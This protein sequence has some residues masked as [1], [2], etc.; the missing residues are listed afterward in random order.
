MP[1][2]QIQSFRGFLKEKL[3]YLTAHNLE[4]QV[5]T[6]FIRLSRGRDYRAIIDEP[7]SLNKTVK[8]D[9]PLLDI[10]KKNLVKISNII[11]EIHRRSFK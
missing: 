11:F 10:N 8:I 6:F 2:K 4:D 7:I 3:K 1:E 5:E 9:R